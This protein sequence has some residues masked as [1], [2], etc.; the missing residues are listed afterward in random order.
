[1]SASRR[2]EGFETLAAVADWDFW[3]SLRLG[4]GLSAT[5]AKRVWRLAL[6]AVLASLAPSAD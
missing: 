4:Q 1:M 2:R 3:E 6:G 5:R